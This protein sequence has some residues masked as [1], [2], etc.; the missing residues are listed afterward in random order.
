MRGYPVAHGRDDD[1]I[2]CIKNLHDPI[3][4]IQIRR[5][6]ASVP[7]SSRID[8][9]V[10]QPRYDIDPEMDRRTEQLVS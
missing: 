4:A 7:S 10:N 3:Q 2:V 9:K 1:A 5:F 8:R 6:T